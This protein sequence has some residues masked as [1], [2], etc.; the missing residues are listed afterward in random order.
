MKKVFI[1]I[2]VLFLVGCSGE[3]LGSSSLSSLADWCI[4][5]Y[6]T[7]SL[8]CTTSIPN[9]EGRLSTDDKKEMLK[10]MEEVFCTTPNRLYT[11]TC[12]NHIQSYLDQEL[13]YKIMDSIRKGLNRY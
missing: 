4:R 1:A 6:V 13:Y 9:I 2:I 3:V 12:R 5:N 8:V 11:T 10:A 7:W